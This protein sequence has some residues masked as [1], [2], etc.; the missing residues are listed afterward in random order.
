MFTF[1]RPTMTDSLNAELEEAASRIQHVN[2]HS[3]RG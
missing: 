2:M 1:M 3:F